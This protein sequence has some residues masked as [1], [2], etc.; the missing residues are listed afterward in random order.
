[1]ATQ[2]FNFEN[3]VKNSLK[4]ISTEKTHLPLF[5]RSMERPDLAMRRCA[6]LLAVQQWRVYENWLART[7]ENAVFPNLKSVGQVNMGFL[8]PDFTTS[9]A[10][11]WGT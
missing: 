4:F 11:A 5:S 8:S 6:I 1:M 2:S 10:Y 3:I 9:R 7:W